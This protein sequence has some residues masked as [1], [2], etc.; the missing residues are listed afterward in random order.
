MSEMNEEE[1]WVMHTVMAF[2][3]LIKRY[4]GKTIWDMMSIEARI[5][6]MGG[7]ND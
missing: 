6:L 2:E 3:E 4:G 5:A 7:E 1:A